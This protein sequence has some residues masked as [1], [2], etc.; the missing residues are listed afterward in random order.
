MK[1][2]NSTLKKI[3]I[4]ILIILFIFSFSPSYRALNLDNAAFVAAMGIDKSDTNNLKVSFEFLS[5]SS[6]GEGSSE[7]TPVINSVDCSSITNGIN[8][9]NAYLGR[10]VNLSHCKLIVFS[11][12]LAKE[13]IS[14]EIFSLINEVQVRPSANIIVSKCNTKYYMENSIPSLGIVIPRYYDIF[15]DTGKYSGYTNNATIGDFFNSLKCNSCEPYAMLGGV[16]SKSST[17]TESDDDTMKAD[18]TSIDG[19][20]KTQN[21]GLAIFKADKLV[22]ELDAIETDCFLNLKGEVNSFLVSVP[23]P[24]N[25]NSKVDIYLTPKANKKIEVSNVNG[26]PYI[27]VQLNFT[28][29]IYSMTNDSKYLNN[30]VL[31]AVSNS[32]DRYLEQQFSEYLYKTSTVYSSD[33]NGFG[34][35]ALSEFNTTNEFNNYG[36]LDNYKNATFDVD[37]NTIINSGFLLTQT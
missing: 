21:I 20:R 13:G 30:E 3:S 17:S 34:L 18:N 36:W 16:S 15:P 1:K 37:V 29:K 2:I 10:K 27:K 12:E 33:I 23:D 31:S 8:M 6:S 35:R 9:M 19:S 32:C 25:N 7:M 11:E 28:G 14:N 24:E 22:G 26:S 4:L 5:P